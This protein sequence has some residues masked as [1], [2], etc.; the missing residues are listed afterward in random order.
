MHEDVFQLPLQRG[1]ICLIFNYKE[2]SSPQRQ[3]LLI[4]PTQQALVETFFVIAQVGIYL[5]DSDDCFA[6]HLINNVK[7]TVISGIS[8]ESH[9]FLKWAQWETSV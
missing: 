7:G 3:L 9:S 4:K 2:K 6:V 5:N 1:I 8:N